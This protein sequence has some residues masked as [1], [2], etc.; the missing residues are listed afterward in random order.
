MLVL[1]IIDVMAGLTL[2][3]WAASSSTYFNKSGYNTSSVLMNAFLVNAP[4]L[5]LS[6]I[7][8]TFNAQYTTIALAREWNRMGATRK[9]LRVTAPKGEQRS[10]YFLQLPYRW[11][12][13]LMITSGGLHWLMSQ[14]I[15]LVRLD[16]R[17]RNGEIDTKESLSACGWSG[18]AL[19]VL[20]VVGG[21]LGGVT[22]V[23]SF[24]P[25]RENVP[26]AT[27]CSAVISAACHPPADDY[28]AHLKEV[29][30]GVVGDAVNGVGHCTFTSLPITKPEVGK[31]YA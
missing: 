23:T 16:V 13:P 31:K 27:S 15:F 26:M 21:C 28:D 19:V 29:Q 18:L 14:A 24:L 30:W 22:W 7:Y 17:D 6:G 2:D 20:T 8:L 10:T 9:G 25:L 5:L 1:I 4:Q 11:A 3:G 12:V